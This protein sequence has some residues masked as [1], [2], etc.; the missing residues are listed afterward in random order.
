MEVVL[1][2][3]ERM[4]AKVGRDRSW[5]QPRMIERMREDGGEAVS[6]APGEQK[7]TTAVLEE[8]VSHKRGTEG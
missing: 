3:R 8:P 5:T 2:E 4:G 1:A 6:A 7:T